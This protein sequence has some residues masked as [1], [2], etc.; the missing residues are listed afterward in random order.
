MSSVWLFAM[1]SQLVACAI[2]N[3]TVGGPAGLA[4]DPEFVVSNPF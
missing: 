2:L 4:Y 3:V 1:L